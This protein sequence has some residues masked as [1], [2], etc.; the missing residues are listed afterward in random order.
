MVGYILGQLK[1]FKLYI[2]SC[3]E[4]RAHRALSYTKKWQILIYNN[5]VMSG[6]FQFLATY[7]II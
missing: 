5:Q 4:C 3:G 1:C 6:I 2:L 7:E